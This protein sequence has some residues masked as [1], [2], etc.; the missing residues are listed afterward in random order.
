MLVAL[1]L[2]ACTKDDTTDDSST[3]ELS[4][5]E[6]EI[7]VEQ[8]PVTESGTSLD[9]CH[10]PGQDWPTQTPDAS[11]QVEVSMSG[12]VLD[13]QDDVPVEEATT[14]FW[15]DNT[16]VEGS[17]DQTVVSDE[18][19][20]ISGVAPTCTPY[21]YST[22][23]DPALEETVLTIQAHNVMPPGESVEDDPNS[24]STTT[25][26]LI[27]GLLGVAVEPGKAV[28]AGTVYGCEREGDAV[29]YAQVI[30]RTKGGDYLEDQDVFYFVDDFP[31]RNQEWTSADG[32]WIIANVPESE[33]TIEVW[34]WDGSEHQLRATTDLTI[35]PDS[36]N[37]ANAY[38]GFEG[39]VV[40]PEECL[41]SCAA[42]E[43]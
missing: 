23:T 27:P 26:Q 32:L 25:Y 2:F 22:Y 28:V 17:A 4:R 24:V 3:G 36:I 39:G 42:V 7:F 35:I 10:T 20:D 31:D 33:L 43:E 41:S 14:E 19:G 38:V 9:T 5:F 8:T 30:A 37:I 40:Y 11:C 15:W 13:F 29:E 6:Q 34:T 18:S 1:A 12:T 21:T 16:Y